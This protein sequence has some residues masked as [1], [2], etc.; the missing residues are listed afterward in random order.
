M[1]III[2]AKEDIPW[3]LN[4]DNAMIDFVCNEEEKFV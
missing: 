3:I 1:V 2:I 4:R